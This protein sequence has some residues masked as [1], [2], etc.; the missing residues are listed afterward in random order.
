M[1]FSHQNSYSAPAAEVYAMLTDQAFREQVC[2]AIKSTRHSVEVTAGPPVVVVVD[3]DQAVRNVPSYAAKVVGTSVRILQ[4]E[5]WTD[6][7]HAD[8]HLTIPGKPGDL[9]ATLS[10]VEDSG[11]TTATTEGDLKVS[12][13]LIGSKLESVV[14]GLVT[15]FL[16]AEAEVGA[17]WLTG[18]R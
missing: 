13:P 9:R 3:Q 8:V 2:S 16:A 4:T 11:V 1:R 5:T 18:D 17:A 14:A 7:S 10:L 15:S 12:I 6:Q